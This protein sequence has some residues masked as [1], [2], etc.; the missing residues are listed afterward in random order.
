MR[1]DE[2]IRYD[3]TGLAELV[4]RREV[5]AAELLAMALDRAAAVE[6]HLN[7]IAVRMDAIGQSR[8]QEALAG[9]FAGVPFLLK[10]IFQDYAG[11][12]AT[13]A[14]R[15]L[16]GVAATAHSTY[17]RRAL[18]AGLVI[19]G[20]TTTP[21]LALLA[22][23]EP[24]LR[25]PTRNPWA[26]ERTPGGS[27]GGA[28]AAVAAGIVPMAGASD[29]GGSIR[30]PAGYCGLFGL[31]PSRGRIP[32]GPMRGETWEGAVTEGVLSRSVRDTA[33]ALDALAG[34]E[35]GDPF[36]IAPPERPF[37]EELERPPGRLRIGFST[38]SPIGGAVHPEAA[39]AVEQA[40]ALL[41]DL[42]HAVEPAAPAIDGAAVA[43]CYLTLYLGQV[44]ADI[45]AIR[46]RT[47]CGAT[48]FELETRLMAKLGRALGAG[49][50]VAAR[51][52]WNGLARTL[53]DF[54][55]THD[56]WLLPTTAGP[57]P[58]IGE[59][60]LRPARRA[61]LLLAERLPVGR[62]MLRAG[63]IETI[64]HDALQQVPFTQ[65][66]NLASVPAMS[67]PLHWAPPAPGA[68]ALP[69]GVQFVAPFGAEG[70]LIRL[71]AQLEQ[72]A[73]WADRR[74]AFPP[75]PATPAGQ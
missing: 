47:G 7:A 13:A 65:L 53:A 69:F 55:A 54:H 67:L 32:V 37:A 5:T 16:L 25:P 72:A 35:P 34:A 6:P 18:A 27:S 10:D 9:P 71:A 14:C 49:A 42:G 64:A 26:P 56:L 24:T 63:V 74:P 60:A 66:A 52:D 19:F 15:P 58:R 45:A 17:T 21:E 44:A 30:I 22:I 3:A 23:T 12:P 33:R 31:K 41:A 40:A 57:P 38:A 61:A 50:Y 59:L 70:L 62:A 20:K 39:A 46:A 28:A 43:R 68:P 2:F 51:R 4:A 73:P 75:P 48:A 8:A 36:A 1:A 11:Q 29:G